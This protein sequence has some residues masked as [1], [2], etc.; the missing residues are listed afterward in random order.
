MGAYPYFVAIIDINGD[1]RQDIINSISDP[2]TI[3]AGNG[4]GTFQPAI[5][6]NA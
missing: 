6:Y 5:Y 4:D 1:G 2:N 3:L